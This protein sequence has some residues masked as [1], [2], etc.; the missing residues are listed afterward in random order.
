MFQV[1][2]EKGDE[3]GLS[4][5]M[6]GITVMAAYKRKQT[7]VAERMTYATVW[8]MVKSDMTRPARKRKTEK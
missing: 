5:N 4:W 3:Y 1:R 6:T 8:W 7:T 2:V